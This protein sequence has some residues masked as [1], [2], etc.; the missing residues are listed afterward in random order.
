MVQFAFGANAIFFTGFAGFQVA[1]ATQFALNRHAQHVRHVDHAAGH[2]DVVA[3]V[4]RRFAVFMQ[5]AVHHDRGKTQVD[6]PLANRWT[7]AVVLVHDQW[8]MRPLLD[9]GLDQML[10][11]GLTGVF[12]G[13]RTGLQDDRSADFVGGCHDGLDLLEIVDIEGR[14][15]VS[16]DGGMVEQFT[17]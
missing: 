8:N 1:Q 2:I 15:T 5:R 17:H 4:G 10:D 6:R 12:P 9:S 13:T 3:K 11:E 16:I 7:L 14:D